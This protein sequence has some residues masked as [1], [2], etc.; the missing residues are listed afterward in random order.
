MYIC[1]FVFCSSTIY[2]ILHVFAKEGLKSHYLDVRQA[3]DR[4]KDGVKCRS[5]YRLAVAS[6]YIQ[7]YMFYLLAPAVSFFWLCRARACWWRHFL[8]GHPRGWR[9]VIGSTSMV[10]VIY[11]EWTSLR[12]AVDHRR[13][14][15]PPTA[16]SVRSTDCRVSGFRSAAAVWRSMDSPRTVR[17]WE[18][19]CYTDWLQIQIYRLLQKHCIGNS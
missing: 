16:R 3:T 9:H 6:P 14:Q 12:H 1:L 15:R 4:T 5:L 19:S 7:S 13:A 2:S 8:F 18:K 10:A 11:Q 17:F